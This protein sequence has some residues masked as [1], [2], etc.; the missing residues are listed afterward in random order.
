MKQRT[1]L[2]TAFLIT[3]KEGENVEVKKNVLLEAHEKTP[4]KT[5]NHQ[6]PN[7]K[8]LYF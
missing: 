2:S 6:K 1:Y 3:T 4:N 7:K 5:T 8:P